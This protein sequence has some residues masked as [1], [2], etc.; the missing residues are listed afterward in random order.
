MRT[1]SPHT[2][3][4]SSPYLPF[5]ASIVVIVLGAWASTS[6][7]GGGT[8][9]PHFAPAAASGLDEA[10]VERAVERAIGRSLD[11]VSA[12]AASPSSPQLDQVALSR[13]VENAVESAVEK[14]VASAAFSESM[15]AAVISS[16]SSPSAA[17]SSLVAA[18]AP[19]ATNN[20]ADAATSALVAKLNA[21]Y[22]AAQA[23]EVEAVA[24]A[25]VCKA[26]AAAAGAGPG[27]LT[28][29][30]RS[31]TSRYPP[32]PAVYAPRAAC[33]AQNF[34]SG[35]GACFLGKCFC[36]AGHEGADCSTVSVAATSCS[37]S[38]DACYRHPTYGSAHVSLERWTRAQWAEALWWSEPV[39]AG[40]IDDNAGASYEL[41]NGYRAVPPALGHVLELG[42]GPFTQLKSL[43]GNSAVPW[44][45]S[46]VTLA[47]PILVSES[48]HGHSSFHTGTFEAHGKL[49]PTRLL[50]VG[51]EEVGQL[52]HDHFD[53]VIM[54][55]V[56][57]H[58]ADAYAV[59]ESM[60][61]ATKVGGIVVFWE[62]MYSATS[63]IGWAGTGGQ[64]LLLDFS[65]PI[66]ESVPAPNWA[67]VN[68]RDTTR[69]RAFDLMAHP[70]RVDASVFEHFASFFE[71]IDYR[72]TPGRRGDMSIVLIG[73]KRT[74]CATPF[75]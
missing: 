74:A 75:H 32:L 33:M 60:Y 70:I 58:V 8:A 17:A 11:K 39:R 26:Q 45:V 64:E 50:Q 18:P 40:D 30:M 4:P 6:L 68:V 71:P 35:K 54:Q 41:F 62:P 34:C 43:L 29:C 56:L 28:K 12:A 27:T 52:Y 73:R 47:D 57:E 72:Q 61:N 5:L 48:R 24:A 66:L 15:K 14:A 25:N 13:A 31:A 53:T 20:A 59:L 49:Y 2:V 42:C 10:I 36:A 63:W 37:L 9:S 38:S 51:A 16:I 7:S 21:A 23:R 3:A 55:N 22:D 44:S 67:D 19:S 1:S 65:L 69:S 46:S